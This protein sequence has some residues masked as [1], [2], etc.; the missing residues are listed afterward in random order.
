MKK[1]PWPGLVYLE[2]LELRKVFREMLL[3]LDGQQADLR[4]LGRKLSE[5]LLNVDNVAE[6]NT[7][8]K[9]V[10]LARRRKSYAEKKQQTVQRRLD[11]RT[12]MRNYMKNY[13]RRGTTPA[14]DG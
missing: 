14:D 1:I 11:R 9:Q 8:R 2:E 7:I 5:Q 6:W 4:F 10:L 3:H 13:R 12:Y